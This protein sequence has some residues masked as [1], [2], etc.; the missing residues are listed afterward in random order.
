MSFHFLSNI[1]LINIIVSPTV[2]KFNL[3]RLGDEV[4]QMS[5]SPLFKAFVSDTGL[6]VIIS[7]YS[8][9]EHI[10]KTT[11][12]SGKVTGTYSGE[13]LGDRNRCVGGPVRGKTA[14]Y[15]VGI[16]WSKMY[17]SKIKTV[18]E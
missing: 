12:K 3:Y 6:N 4:S 14:K 13:V 17:K 2:S 8:L 16:R 18:S 1:W 7:P 15:H 11:N 10:R 9:L 5:L